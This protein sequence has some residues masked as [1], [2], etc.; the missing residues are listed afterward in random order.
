M[1]TFSKANRFDLAVEDE[2]RPVPKEPILLVDDERSIVEILGEFL[3]NEGYEYVATTCPVEALQHL[4]ERK[5]ALLLTDL[6]M[7]K[8]HGLEVVREAKKLDPDLAIV[9]ISALVETK[10][11]V[12]AMRL[13]ADDYLIKPFNLMEVSLCV[14]RAIEKRGL[15]LDNRRHQ[16]ELESRVRE[17]TADLE[18]T[19]RELLI[20]KEYLESLLHSTVDA[21]ITTNPKGVVDFANDG[22]VR[23]LG[24]PRE[25][26]LGMS[27]EDLFVK[28]EEEAL[29]I[30]ALIEESMPLQNHET[31][32]RHRS[33]ASVPVNMSLSFVYDAQG[34]VISML[35]ICRDITHQKELEAVLK[36]LSTKDSLTGLYN[37]RYFYERL[38]TEIERARRQ[39]HPLSLLLFDIDQFK[40]YNDRFGHLAGDNVL[41]VAGEVVV[42]CTRVHVDVGCRY[43]GDEFTVILP[44]ADEEQAY[45]VATRILASFNARK[46]EGISLSIGLMTYETGYPLRRF[47]QF[48]DAMMYDA[49]RAGGDQ[50]SVYRPEMNLPVSGE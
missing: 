25:E 29:A 27:V 22:A 9:V 5:F 13:G 37:Q 38:A 34:E 8:M 47:I 33:G 45:N 24:C 42:E 17:A 21:I 36:D 32:L 11:A 20:T 28:G 18:R 23:M 1:D 26:F 39:Q 7:P 46:F 48:T 19:N 30:R 6:K 49:K 35:A 31:E 2:K 41:Q 10:N 3:G 15:V 4:K 14:A 43:G 50:I 40:H 12:Q 44:E 16:V